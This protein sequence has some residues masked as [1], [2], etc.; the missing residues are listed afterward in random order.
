MRTEELI[1]QLAGEA[2]PVQRLPA[3]HMRMLG[4]LLASLPF[5]ALVVLVMSPRPDLAAK[6]GE[7]RFLIEQGAA[8]ATAVTAAIAAFYLIIPGANRRV[9]LLPAVPFT[10][11]VTTLGLGC[12]A[13]W[14]RYGL[15]GLRITPDLACF[16]NIAL[17]G[18]LPAVAIVVMLRR[19]APLAPHTTMLLGGLAAAALG[20]FGLRFFHAQDAGI[21]VLLWQFGSVIALSLIA[22]GLGQLLLRWRYREFR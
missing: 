4:W 18:A 7:A 21:M 12:I 17:V 14:L 13:D 8:F 1:E 20:S 3:P 11:W 2:R 9:A 22:G 19:G 10:A 16:P 15:D 5:V 6:L